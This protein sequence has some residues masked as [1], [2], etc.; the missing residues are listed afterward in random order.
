[1]LVSVS[2]PSNVANVPVVGKVT[3]VV[4][5]DVNVVANAPDVVRF[6]PS[7]IVLPLLFTPVPPY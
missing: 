7:V 2:V 5:V 6:P 3:V 1:L 4:A